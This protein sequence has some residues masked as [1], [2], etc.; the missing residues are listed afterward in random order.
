VEEDE[1]EKPKEEE[2]K[3][4]LAKGSRTRKRVVMEGCVA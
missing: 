2:K 3:K 4:P 1:E